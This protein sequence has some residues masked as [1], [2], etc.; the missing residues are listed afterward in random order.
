MHPSAESHHLPSTMYR[1]SILMGRPSPLDQSLQHG[2]R[3]RRHR[4]R[5][6]RA[7]DASPPLNTGPCPGTGLLHSPGIRRRRRPRDSLAGTPHPPSRPPD[8]RFGR[9]IHH[10]L[11]NRPCLKTAI[12]RTSSLPV[13]LCF[14]RKYHRKTAPDIG[15]STMPVS[16]P[17]ANTPPCDGAETP[18]PKRT[19][20]TTSP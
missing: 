16:C 15:H 19:F 4:G 20:P 1:S 14:T 12:E 3:H 10:K 5:V 7:G 6:R 2:L 11:W 18:F 17:S 8:G 13:D 9:R